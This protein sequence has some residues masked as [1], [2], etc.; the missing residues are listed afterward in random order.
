[1][2]SAVKNS[3]SHC[4]GEPDGHGELHRH[5][6]LD[7]ILERF[8]EDRIT[9]N[10]RGGQS[11]Y[12]HLTKWLPQMKSDRRRRERDKENTKNLSDFKA[13]FMVVLRRQFTAGCV[14][15]VGWDVDFACHAGTA[16]PFACN[17]HKTL[18]LTG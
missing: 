12:T 3:D 6:A 4:R 18:Q 13:V 1:M 5:A 15:G 7:D 14:C 9:A 17:A 8:L 10:H 16:M 11:K 2:T